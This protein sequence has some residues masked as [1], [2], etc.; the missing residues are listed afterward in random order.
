MTG[1]ANYPVY[2]QGG[3]PFR[4]MPTTSPAISP[5]FGCQTRLRP[6]LNF[7]DTQGANIFPDAIAVPDQQL[8]LSAASVA[9]SNLLADSSTITHP[10]YNYGEI[11]RF[12]P[13]VGKIIFP[14]SY[15]SDALIQNQIGQSRDTVDSILAY[16]IA[17][18]RRPVVAK[19]S[20]TLTLDVE[21]SSQFLSNVTSADSDKYVM[22]TFNIPSASTLVV[23]PVG[24]GQG[25]PSIGSTSQ[26]TFADRVVTIC[27][28]LSSIA[29]NLG[30]HAKTQFDGTALNP[31]Y[32]NLGT[33]VA[34]RILRGSAA[35]SNSPLSPLYLKR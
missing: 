18:T 4:L 15:Y 2:A 24:I 16:C 8:E 30:T 20:A 35:I 26:N 31:L 21:I 14:S 34:A 3:K 32:Y 13:L 17:S 19:A 6:V 1:I 5:D 11:T 28:P 12:S 7:N 23:S 25:T 27:L 9:F 22:V 29:R 33:Q 10:E